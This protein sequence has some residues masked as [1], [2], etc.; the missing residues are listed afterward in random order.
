MTTLG[1]SNLIVVD[2][3]DALLIADRNEINQLKELI[4]TLE[5]MNIKNECFYPIVQKPWGNYEIILTSKEMQIK[6]IKVKPGASLSLQ[7]HKYRSEVWVVISGEADVINDS[8]T[9]TLKA[10]ESTFIPAGNKHRLS[11]K[12][13]YEL[14]IVEIQTGEYFGEDDIVRFDDAYGRPIGSAM[15]DSKLLEE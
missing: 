8:L 14:T 12:S 4:E 9:L 5:T 2:T 6:R 7:K 15:S 11:N 3:E 1:V 10:G 13:G